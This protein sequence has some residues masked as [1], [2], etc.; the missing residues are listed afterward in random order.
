MYLQV[1]PFIFR[2]NQTAI[3][4][5]HMVMIPKVVLQDNSCCNLSHKFGLAC[6]NLNRHFIRVFHYKIKYQ[7]GRFRMSTVVKIKR[8]YFSSYTLFPFHAFVRTSNQKYFYFECLSATDWEAHASGLIL[9]SKPEAFAYPV[10]ISEIFDVP[11]SFVE[12]EMSK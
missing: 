12:G 3:V 7:T 10:T 9:Q 2:N 5:L 11:F 6:D 1:F 8:F 4:C